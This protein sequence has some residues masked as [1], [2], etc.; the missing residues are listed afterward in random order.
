MTLP[1]IVVPTMREGAGG[2]GGETAR[3]PPPSATPPFCEALEGPWPPRASA[4]L[5][6]IVEFVIRTPPV[7]RMPTPSATP[8]A[9]SLPPATEAMLSLTVVSTT[10]SAPPAAR[11]PTPSAKPPGLPGAPLRLA[12]LFVTT[13]LRR[14]RSA[15]TERIPT[16]SPGPAEM[17]PSRIVTP[18]NIASA[19]PSISITRN[20]PPARMI[21]S[22]AAWPA[23][24]TL[25][26]LIKS[27][28]LVSV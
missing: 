24:V 18:L 15:S 23:I 6:L 5:P 22:A 25:F 7:A 4:R 3:I 11:M 9:F 1:L 10:V 28:P 20:A 12:V 21:V 14:V 27:G 17:L 13:E 16:P 26:S 19:G 8:P 2:G